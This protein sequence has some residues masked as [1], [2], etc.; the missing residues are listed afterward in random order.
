[1]LTEAVDWWATRM[2]EL[3]PAQLTRRPLGWA[4][5]VIVVAGRSAGSP[6]TLLLR[7]NRQETLLGNFINGPTDRGTTRAAL[8]GPPRDLPVLLRPPPGALLEKPL[9]LPMAAERELQRVIGYEMNR[10]TPFELD[11]VFWTW[12]IMQRDHSRG[13]LHVRLSLVPKTGLWPLITA[14]DD[15]GLSPAA[16][17]VTQ[18]SGPPRL[19]PLRQDTTRLAWQR[20]VAVALGSGCGALAVVAVALPFFLQSLALGAVQDRI[21]AVQPQVAEAQSLRQRIA[22]ENAGQNAIADARSR[23]GNTLEVLAAI[24]QLLPDDTFLNDLALHQRRLTITGQSAAA[25]K[26]IA[27]LAADPMFHNPGFAAPVTR[28]EAAGRD[29][30]SIATEVGR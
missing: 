5:A 2:T 26:L 7:R 17:E 19:I 18:S 9:V 24:T 3:M 4:N 20:R 23:L 22:A 8:N 25:P 10:V 21:A 15:A 30:F 14:L 27:A 29:V 13:R 16:L 28:N 12:D 1:M 6:A 11:D